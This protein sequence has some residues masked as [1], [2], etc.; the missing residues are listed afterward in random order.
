[1]K[2]GEVDTEMGMVRFRLRMVARSLEDTAERLQLARKDT[3]ALQRDVSLTL[4]G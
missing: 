3:E 2:L 1:M 4:M